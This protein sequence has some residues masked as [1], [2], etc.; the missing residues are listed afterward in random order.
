MWVSA[1]IL[2]ATFFGIFTEGVL[3]FH[4]TKF[5]MGGA[6]LMV[7]AGQYF[8]FYDPHSADARRFSV[9]EARG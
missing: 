1:V 2:I 8:G 6:G 5:A 9:K 3:G 7:L 4:R